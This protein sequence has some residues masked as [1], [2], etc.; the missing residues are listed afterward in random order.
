MD[1][2]R[3]M[4]CWIPAKKSCSSHLFGG[5][6]KPVCSDGLRAGTI[7]SHNFFALGPILVKFHI[8]TRLIE[9]FS[10]IIWTWWWGEEKLHFTP[11]HTLRQLKCDEALIPPLRRVVEFWARYRQIP[12]R[13]F[14]GVGKI[15]RPCDL[16]SRSYKRLYTHT[17]ILRA[18]TCL[19]KGPETGGFSRVLGVVGII[20]IFMY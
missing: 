4:A 19:D 9:S 17:V 14:W 15:W 12:V 2:K 16:R 20:S 1:S 5:G 11:F 10:T 13:G 3:R 18:L 7:E 6:P 8:Q